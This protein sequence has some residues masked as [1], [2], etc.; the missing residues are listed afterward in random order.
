MNPKAPQLTGLFSFPTNFHSARFSER[1]AKLYTEIVDDA[2]D[3]TVF[4]L[5]LIVSAIHFTVRSSGKKLMFVL[6]VK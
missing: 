6:V 2:L 3:C 5:E 4:A 1:D